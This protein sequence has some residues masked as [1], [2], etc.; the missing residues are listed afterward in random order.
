MSHQYITDTKSYVDKLLKF[1]KCETSKNAKTNV[2][3][4]AFCCWSIV[5]RSTQ[6]KFKHRRYCTVVKLNQEMSDS[7]VETFE[8]YASL[9][10]WKKD[11]KVPALGYNLPCIT[12]ADA[13]EFGLYSGDEMPGCLGSGW[14]KT[15]FRDSDECK[16]K[17]SRKQMRKV[18]KQ[19]PKERKNFKWFSA[20]NLS[21]KKLFPTPSRKVDIKEEKEEIKEK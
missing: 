5:K 8:H 19:P 20:K 11:G 13:I 16:K 6:K 3:I 1:L 10:N 12:K 15:I 18:F 14:S 7:P 4:I 2:T 17:T 9:F 21:N